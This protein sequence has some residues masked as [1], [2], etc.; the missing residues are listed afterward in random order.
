MPDVGGDRDP[1]FI[2]RHLA[3]LAAWVERYHHSEVEGLDRVPPGPALAVGNHNGGIMA[4]DTLAL[5]AAWWRHFGV[6]EPSYGLAH[7]VA[8]R[9]PGLRELLL[10]VG[11]VPARQEVALALLRRGSKVLV[12]PGG[13]LDAFRPASRAGEVVFGARRGF[14]RAA[15]RAR[16]PIVPIVSAGAHEAFHVLT[17]GRALVRRLRLKR[18]TRI[19]VLPLVLCLPWGVAVGP[20]PY[21]PLPVRIRVRVLAPIAWDLPAEAADDPAT[22]ARCGD[23]VVCA[24]QTGLDAL[25]RE[26]GH[27]RVARLRAL[28]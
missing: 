19:E 13:D 4:P 17:D 18:L 6:D 24:M 16:V 23:E 14:V 12:Y 9:V 11:A 22:V 20:L 21:L 28:G 8:F 3:T 7:D 5:M 2:R 25:S 1:E 10:R 15:L 26:G 27:G